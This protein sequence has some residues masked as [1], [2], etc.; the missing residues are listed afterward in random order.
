MK[1][2]ES[3]GCTSAREIRTASKFSAATL[4]EA[5]GIQCALPSPIKPLG[6]DRKVC[7]PAY[8]VL[9]S[10]GDN[11]KIHQAIYAAHP[12]DAL[13]IATGGHWEAGYLGEILVSAALERRLSGIVIDGCV[14]DGKELLQLPLSVFCRGLCVRGTTKD[15]A[16]A[17]GLGQTIRIHDVSIHPGDLIVGDAD[18]VVVLPHEMVP[19]VL[20]KAQARVKGER[21]IIKRIHG[22]ERTVD[23]FGV[24]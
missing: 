3:V 10:P 9:T 6:P 23:I 12:G 11:R 13:V 22:N 24:Q 20:S 5:S 4:F 7:G 16:L 1:D 2:R 15:K 21:E 17:G 8:T 19:E 18:G 14:R